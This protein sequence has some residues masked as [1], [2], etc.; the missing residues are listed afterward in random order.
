MHRN[1]ASIAH[2]ADYGYAFDSDAWEY[3]ARPFLSCKFRMYQTYG[4]GMRQHSNDLPV[5]EDFAIDYLNSLAAAMLEDEALAE[6]V[7][8]LHYETRQA[9][10]QFAASLVY[11]PE[12]DSGF[13]RTRYF[14]VQQGKVS[15]NQEK[16][17]DD[18]YKALSD[19]HTG[20]AESIYKILVSEHSEGYERWQLANNVRNWAVEHLKNYFM[21]MPAVF[22]NWFAQDSRKARAFRDAHE[23]CEGIAK[24]CR[25]RKN[26]IAHVINYRA[27]LDRKA[28]RDVL[29]LTAEASTEAA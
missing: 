29:Q 5:I 22:L 7:G 21:E 24:A 16:Q 26:A 12:K 6:E 10:M 17:H 13:G 19:S 28:Q 15:R 2:S 23:A 27:E 4:D 20:S 3:N 9:L 11:H 18:R 8:R 1:F 14:S 25:Y